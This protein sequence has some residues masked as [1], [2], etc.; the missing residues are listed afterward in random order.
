MRAS[1]GLLSAV[2]TVVLAAAG[3]AGAD[4]TLTAR[5]GPGSSVQLDWTAAGTVYGVYRSTDSSTLGQPKNLRGQTE[6]TTWT[7]DPPESSI[8]YYLVKAPA[9]TIDADCSSGHCVDGA[10]C[11]AGCAGACE[12][13]DLAGQVGTCVPIPGNPDPAGDCAR[14]CATLPPLDEGTCEVIPGTSGQTLLVGNVLG[15]EERY[16]GGEV[17]IEATGLIG[18]V[19]CGCAA[20]DPQATVVRCPS[21]VISPGLINSIDFLN[22]AQ[23]PP[24]ADTGERYEHRH[25]WRVGR[26]GHTRINAPSGTLDQMR[27]GELRQ[28]MGGATST[29]GTTG[30]AGLQRNLNAAVRQEGLGQPEIL[31]DTFPLGDSN[32]AMND[33]G[34]AYPSIRPE[35]TI[36]DRD[37]FLATVAEGISTAARNEFLCLS[38]SANGGQDLLQ[39]QSTFRHAVGVT[40]ADLGAMATDGAG[41]IWSPRSNISLY[42]DTA[43]VTM[44]ARLGVPIA[45]GTDWII[46]GSMNMLRE[47]RC[48][49]SFDGDYLGDFFTDRDLWR[50]VTFRPAELTATDDAIGTIAPGR[51]ADLA[52][53]DGASSAGYR[54]LIDA[55]A[56]G[57]VLVM[58]AGAALYGDTALVE[59]LRGGGLDCDPLD[60]CGR[61]KKVCLVGEIGQTLPELQASVG[62]AYG[63]FFCGTPAYEPTCRPRREYSVWGSTV[64]DG[65]PTTDDPDGDGIPTTSDNCPSVF[66]PVRPMDATVQPDEDGD[67][68]GDACDPCPLAVA[69][70][71]A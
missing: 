39:P 1:T 13:C 61:A 32:G 49:D 31:V 60:V 12:A 2:L 41:L 7:E 45:L 66:N 55:E 14:T 5:R 26:N 33:V 37:A 57:V 6:A 16:L 46:S 11:N 69:C 50:M 59:G 24:H 56:S 44:A 38:S 9:C 35:S 40:A 47:L 71:G 51:V 23:N 25:E 52:I 34:C 68:A 19:G 53:F 8:Q 17:L 48:A 4:V 42:G 18:C 70:P 54:A 30:M 58:R 28:I 15:F 67:G 22:Y 20:V 63:L 21:G 65:V 36:A 3:P 29:A 43:R 27:W 64:Y 62:S 10:C